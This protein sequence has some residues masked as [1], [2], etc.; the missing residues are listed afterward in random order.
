MDPTLQ[1][2]SQVYFWL[3]SLTPVSENP[4][5]SNP[6]FYLESGRAKHI[7]LHVARIMPRSPRSRNI[8]LS[9]THEVLDEDEESEH[10][11][12]QVD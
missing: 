1:L 9:V 4:I 12:Q 5:Q 6:A 8:A 2:P 11:L 3:R 7:Q 10:G